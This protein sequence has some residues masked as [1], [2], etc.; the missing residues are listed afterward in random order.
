MEILKRI[1]W[2][3]PR[4]GKEEHK[5]IAQVLNSNFPNEGPLTKQFEEKIAGLLKS[6]FAIAVPNGT[7]AMFLSLKALGVGHGD[8]VIVPDMTFIATANAVEMAGAKPILA[9]VDRKSLT[10]DINSFKEAITQKTK[11]VIPVHITGR[12]ADMQSILEIAN[13]KG[14]KVVEDAAEAFMSMHKGKHL[15]T[16]GSTGCF[17]FSPQ[18]TI[19]TGQGGAVV[20]DDEAIY[21]KLVELKDQGRPVRG[22]GG[23]DIHFSVGYNFKFTDLQ[24]ALGLGQLHY[25]QERLDRIKRTYKIYQQELCGANGIALFSF[26]ADAGEQPQWVDAAVEKRA[27]FEQNLILGNM[28][29]RRFWLPVHTQKPY[30]LKDENFP[31]SIAMSKKSLW[32]PSAYTLNDTDI[33]NV[34]ARIKAFLKT[35]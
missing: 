19:T 31:N 24:A 13:K 27:E 15:G 30:R 10:I 2:W 16:Y 20:T 1:P 22:T 14:I 18:K 8:E 7:S 17:S 23:D 21:R 26:D 29:C 6:K 9:D 25:L 12:A 11:A 3:E 33:A 34:C 28:H 4:I 32:L 5:Y 35:N